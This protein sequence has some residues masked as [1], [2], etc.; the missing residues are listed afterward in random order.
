MSENHE[1]KLQPMTPKEVAVWEQMVREADRYA[2]NQAL[3]NKLLQ[4]PV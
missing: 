1:P 2:E 4:K 3:M